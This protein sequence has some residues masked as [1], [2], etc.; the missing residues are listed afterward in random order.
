M[1]FGWFLDTEKP[2]SAVLLNRAFLV[3]F[4]YKRFFCTIQTTRGAQG[5]T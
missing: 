1:S 5:G 3:V 2:D 4:L